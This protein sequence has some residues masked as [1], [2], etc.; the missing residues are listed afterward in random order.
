MNAI[1]NRHLCQIYSRIS[2]SSSINAFRDKELHA[3]SCHIILHLHE[4]DFVVYT[5]SLRGNGPCVTNERLPDLNGS[6]TYRDRKQENHPTSY[7]AMIGWHTV[8]IK[9]FESDSLITVRLVQK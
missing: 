3:L 7:I 9:L 2:D 8:G 4:D 5:M 6:I 1:T